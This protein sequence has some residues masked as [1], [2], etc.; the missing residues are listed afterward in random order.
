M[1]Y[2]LLV[3]L[4]GNQ[5]VDHLTMQAFY[6]S[7]LGGGQVAAASL[8]HWSSFTGLSLSSPASTV[9]TGLSSVTPACTALCSNHGRCLDG[10]STHGTS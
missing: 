3:V 2:E 5:L 4:A 8:I 7:P 1:H 9:L 6:S 10:T